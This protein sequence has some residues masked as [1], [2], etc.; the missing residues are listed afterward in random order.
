[1]IAV[2]SGSARGVGPTAL[3][4]VLAVAEPFYAGAM[5]LR[6]RLY[7]SG[8][9]HAAKLGRPVISIGNI[10]TGGTGKTPMVRWLAERLRDSGRRVAIL[11]RGYKAAASE[12]GDELE[13]LKSALNDGPERPVFLAANPDRAAAAAGLLGEH[14]EIDV[15]LLD[16]GFQHRRVRRDLDVVLVS[17]AEPF[18]FGHVLPR[19]LLREPL[20]GLGRAGA[21]VITHCDQVSAGELSRIESV[22]REH[23]RAS[24]S[25]RVHPLYRAVHEQTGLRPPQAGS[26]GPPPQP[27]D[28]L[29]GRSFFAFCGIGTPPAFDA[30]LRRF[31]PRY[32]GSR[33]FADHHA[34]GE[35]DLQWLRGKA[36]EKGADLLL[37]T[38]KDWAKISRLSTAQAEPHIWRV[39][40]TMKFVGDDETRLLAQT[41]DAISAS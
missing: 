20:S 39:D 3:R 28:W 29:S 5:L 12:L 27:I 18:G 4:G 38:E 35:S 9:L 22:I 36:K 11:S 34:Y 40:M 30:P 25:Q 37:T 23:Q 14:P 10:T 8:Y 13:M 41:V 16:D 2:M 6:N 32:V 26:S 15:F 1:M 24:G 21:V 19:G 31:G 17:A 7:D 33:W